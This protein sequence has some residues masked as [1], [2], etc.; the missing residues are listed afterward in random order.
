LGGGTA[1]GTY[2]TQVT[3][4]N[5][6]L[7]RPANPTRAG[8][9]FGGWYTDAAFTNKHNFTYIYLASYNPDPGI[10]GTFRIPK[11]VT[12]NLDLYAKWYP[13]TPGGTHHLLF[14]A[15]IHW[16]TSNRTIY[17]EWM[18]K[19]RTQLSG[20][21]LDFVGFCGDLAHPSTAGTGGVNYWTNVTQLMEVSDS[22]LTTAPSGFIKYDSLYAMGNHAYQTS[23]GG[24]LGTLKDRTSTQERLV[25][26]EEVI[27]T[28]D[29]ILFALSPVPAGDDAGCEQRYVHETVTILGD[30]LQ[31]A[32]TNIPIFIMAHHP[33]HYL[34]NDRVTKDAAPM[35]DLLNNY[36]NV[37]FLWGHNHSR[38]EPSYDK[39]FY[40]GSTIPVGNSTTDR[41]LN[42][43]Y[44]SAGAM[45][46]S[47][48]TGD[49]TSKNILGKGLV[50]AVNNGK[51]T[52][53]YYNKD[54]NPM[55]DVPTSGTK[56]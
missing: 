25:D 36:P 12:G 29:Y 10:N 35:V 6:S 16:D 26:R 4:G 17:E 30:Y 27:R 45:R 46:D 51:V 47:E 49:Q 52:F 19:L 39:I 3:K 21:Q 5:P 33:L 48:Y 38:A 14:I 32:P 11:P 28:S 37:I 23:V 43:T 9:I 42:F 24:W 40:P 50:A 22:Y 20:I 18:P 55:T 54:G 7:S 41:T 56:P 44:L 8:H 53:T 2:P 15:D 34:T 1:G 13:Y 31:T